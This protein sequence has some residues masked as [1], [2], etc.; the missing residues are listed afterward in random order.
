MTLWVRNPKSLVRSQGCWGQAQAGEGYAVTAP[1]F[2]ATVAPSHLHIQG[3]GSEKS[4]ETGRRW[5]SDSYLTG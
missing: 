2:V 1:H 4:S 5:E 3:V